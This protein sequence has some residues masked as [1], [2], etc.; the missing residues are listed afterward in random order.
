MC[1]EHS[2]ALEVV[3]SKLREK[4]DFS[5]EELQKDILAQGGVLRIAPGF[6]VG[7]Y[8]A[9]LEEDGFI[10]F[11]PVKGQFHVRD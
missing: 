6:T 7:E 2:T 9:E 4:Q 11:D 1:Q 10:E 5:F 3:K 8:V